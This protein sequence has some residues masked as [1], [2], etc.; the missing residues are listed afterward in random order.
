MNSP[1][2]TPRALRWLATAAVFTTTALALAGLPREDLPLPWLLAFTLPGAVLGCWSRLSYSPWGRALL[3]VTLQAT[4]CWSALELVGPMTRPAALSCTILPPLAFATTRNHDRDP[5]LALFLSLCVLLVGIILQ[6]LQIWLL[7]G[8]V[9]TSFLSLHAATLLRSYRVTAPRRREHGLGLQ[10]IGASGLLTLSCVLSVFAVDRAITCLPSPSRSDEDGDQRS[11]SRVGDRLEVGLDDTFSFGGDGGV[12]SELKGEQLVRA[13]GV[14]GAVTPALYLRCGFFAVA[15]LR[16]WEIGPLQV[17]PQSE[18]DGHVFWRSEPRAKV[19]TL[20]LERYA[21]ASKFVFLPPHTTRLRGI[22]GLTVDPVREWIRP[23]GQNVAPYTATWL[24]FPPLPARAVVDRRADVDELTQLP[25]RLDRK[26]YEAL[27]NDWGVGRDPR[28]AM[29][30]IAAGLAGHCRYDRSTPTGPFAQELENFLFAEG[31]RHGYCMHFASAAALM[32]R[33][34][35]IPC[36]IA[37]GL[38]GGEASRDGSGARVYGSQHAHAWVELPIAR[39]GF[40]IFDPTPPSGR[41]RSLPAA[42]RSAAAS[43]LT[44]GDDDAVY[45]PTLRAVRDALRAPWLLPALLLLTLLFAVLPRR[46]PKHPKLTASQAT[47]KVRRALQKLMRALARAGHRRQ[48]GQTL[49]H[50]ADQLEA[51]GHTTPDVRAAFAAYQEVRFGGRPFDDDRA[52]AMAA[53]TR[54]ALTMRDSERP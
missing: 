18:P 30:A 29:T 33:M 52:R 34:R 19:R 50:F 46:A 2:A 4:A 44:A 41:G 6:G 12:L 32:L 26:P 37:V 3:A 21:G 31:D 47:P 28:Q 23:L 36:R 22:E 24:E 53:G 27:L 48:H 1:D 49:E 9:I 15:G 45:E 43:D 11:A 20:Q 13:T 7:L 16:R 14:D 39:R 35:G 5:S 40:Q 42:Q 17:R 54:A 51:A 38:Y 25:D 8:Y 10:E